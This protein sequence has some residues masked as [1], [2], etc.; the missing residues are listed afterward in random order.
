MVD[1]D[2]NGRLY[3]FGLLYGKTFGNIFQVN[4]LG[5][6]GVLW[7]YD[8]VTISHGPTIP[9]TY[10]DQGYTTLNIPLEI[11]VG[12]IPVKYIGISMG[13]FANFNSKKPMIGFNLKLEF[14]KIR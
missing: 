13:G 4:I 12:L 6:I 2:H 1:E 14:G 10:R 5:G 7:G 9:P 11:G 3:D 8:L